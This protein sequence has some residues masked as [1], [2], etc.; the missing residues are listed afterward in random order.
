MSETMTYTSLVAD[1]TTYAERSDDPF[2]A[3]VDRFIMMAENRLA[4]EAKLLGFQRV[5]TGQLNGNTLTKPERWRKTKSFSLV[6]GGERHYLRERGYEYCREYWPVAA[7][8]GVPLFYADY[9]YNEYFLAPT[10]AAAYDFELIY[11]ERPQP[12]SS[13]NQTNWTTEYAP[14]LLLYAAMLE[15][16]PFL[17]TGERIPEFQ[18]L[19]DRALAALNGEDA[20]RVEDATAKRGA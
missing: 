4:S 12:L 16:M 15:A 19:Y 3:Q 9:D 7:T 17:K 2:L 1:I 5:V 20:Q 10:P 8:T 18:G 6:I 11:W 13:S 14:Q